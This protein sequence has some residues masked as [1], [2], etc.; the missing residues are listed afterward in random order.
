MLFVVLGLALTEAA[1]GAETTASS[2]SPSDSIGNEGEGGATGGFAEAAPAGGPVPEGVFEDGTSDPSA[3]ASTP[4]KKNGASNL[5]AS[6]IVGVAVTGF[7]L[8]Y[9]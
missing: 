4:P 3:E 6:T 2:P 7:S 1:I 9:F 8:F 5:E